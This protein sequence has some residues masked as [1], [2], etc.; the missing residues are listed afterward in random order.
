[1]NS[2]VY[3]R[4]VLLDTSVVFARYCKRDRRHELALATLQ[5]VQDQVLC[6]VNV[7]A[8]ETFTRLRYDAGLDDALASYEYLREHD[9]R[10][11][12]FEARDEESAMKALRKYTDKRL[13]FIDALCAAVM[14]RNGIYR[15]ASFDSD[16]YAFGFEVIPGPALR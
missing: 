6:A 16:F 2:S 10:I 12:D 11:L 4:L 14:M 8:H 3:T 7:T 13:S 1:M 15:V 9:V 5:A